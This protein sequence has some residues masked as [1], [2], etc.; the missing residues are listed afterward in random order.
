MRFAGA[1]AAVCYPYR[2]A[3]YTDGQ[4]TLPARQQKSSPRVCELAVWRGGVSTNTRDCLST[5]EDSAAQLDG[6][7]R[8][9]GDAA[10]DDPLA[11]TAGW[12]A[13]AQGRQAWKQNEEYFVTAA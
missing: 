3:V 12:M 2:G 9:F 13:L 7:T 5:A 8:F 4:G 6:L 1:S 10:A 11:N